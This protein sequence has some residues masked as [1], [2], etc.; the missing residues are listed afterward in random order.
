MKKIR[1]KTPFG[2]IIAKLLEDKC[3]NTAAIIYKN[4]PMSYKSILRVWGEEVF[5]HTPDTWEKIEYENA[6]IE[7]EVGD[8][9][10]WPRDPAICLFFGKTPL[11][12]GDKPIAAEPINVFAKIIKGFEI[13]PKLTDGDS[14][15]MDT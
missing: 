11:S 1:F 15:L 5:F 10:Y 3:P 2:D 4:L 8:V 7:L 9:A 14:I 12:K 13:F 6:Q